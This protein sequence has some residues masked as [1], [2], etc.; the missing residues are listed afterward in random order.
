[1]SERSAKDKAMAVAVMMVDIACGL[2]R[3]AGARVRT[4]H[5]ELD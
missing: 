5:I 3:G 4:A 2:E 1:M